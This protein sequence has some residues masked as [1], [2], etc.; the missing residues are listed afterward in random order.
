MTDIATEH[1]CPRCASPVFGGESRCGRCRAAVSRPGLRGRANEYRPGKQVI[2]VSN[3]VRTRRRADVDRS[4][5][6]VWIVLLAGVFLLVS[7]GRSP[8]WLCLPILMTTGSLTLLAGGWNRFRIELDE[9]GD[10]RRSDEL[11]MS[12]VIVRLENGRQRVVRLR[13][14]PCLVDAGDTVRIIHFTRKRWVLWLRGSGGYMWTMGG[15]RAGVTCVW[16]IALTFAV[17]LG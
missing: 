2:V 13:G 1:R 10:D 5:V 15:I 3:V 9:F 4:A 17:A 7:R 11:L 16:I 14:R 12:N 6:T 8:L